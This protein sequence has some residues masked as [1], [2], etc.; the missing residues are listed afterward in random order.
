[1]IVKQTFISYLFGL[2]NGKYVNNFLLRNCPDKHQEW[3]QVSTFRQLRARRALL[4]CKD[5]PL[6]AR[7]ALSLY[8]VYGSSALLVLNGTSLNCSNALLAL[9]WRFVKSLSHQI[10]IQWLCWT[11]NAWCCGIVKLT[12]QLTMLSTVFNRASELKYTWK[13]LT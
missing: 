9:N 10:H 12:F 13:N 7:R 6:R 3:I 5:D 11:W 1:M 4:Q 8:K 2:Q